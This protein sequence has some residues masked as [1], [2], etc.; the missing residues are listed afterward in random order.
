[1]YSFTPFTTFIHVCIINIHQGT[2]PGVYMK[3]KEIATETQVWDNIKN[4]IEPPQCHACIR[5]EKILQGD[6]NVP[7]RVSI[8]FVFYLRLSTFH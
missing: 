1:M 6:D 2:E 7:L 4:K 8:F 3:I 5:K